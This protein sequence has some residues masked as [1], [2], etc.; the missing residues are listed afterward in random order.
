MPKGTL[1]FFAN[2]P[3]LTNGFLR[4]DRSTTHGEKG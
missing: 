3:S 1:I 4:D 2:L